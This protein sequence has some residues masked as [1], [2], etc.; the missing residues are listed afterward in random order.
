VAAN[1]LK[2]ELKGSENLH[3]VVPQFAEAPVHRMR[4]RQKAEHRRTADGQAVEPDF[5]ALVVRRVP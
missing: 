2:N 5:Q 3:R 1:A 4:A